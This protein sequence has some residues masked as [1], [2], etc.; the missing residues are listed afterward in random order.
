[1]LTFKPA[2]V[3]LA[4]H[5]ITHDAQHHGQISMLASQVGQPLSPKIDFGLWEWGTLWRESGFGK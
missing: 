4:G 3:G 2:V 5:M 1:V